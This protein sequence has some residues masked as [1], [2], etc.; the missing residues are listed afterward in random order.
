MRNI[1]PPPHTRDIS[2]PNIRSPG[3]MKYFKQWILKFLNGGRP[4][5]LLPECLHGLPSRH[6]LLVW[7]SQS[8]FRS[9]DSGNELFL[10]FVWTQLFIMDKARL[11]RCEAWRVLT[12]DHH[13]LVGT[14][15]VEHVQ[16]VLDLHKVH[17]TSQHL[18]EEAFICYIYI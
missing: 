3:I 8:G 9:G 14:A 16:T 15:G 10:L 17:I 2:Q 11:W 13:G 12:W 7:I 6:L 5:I 1:L 18:Q 4:E